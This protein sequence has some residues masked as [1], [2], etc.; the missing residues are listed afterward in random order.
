MSDNSCAGRSG[1][2]GFAQD[3]DNILSVTELDYADFV[4][5][6]GHFEITHLQPHA[7]FHVFKHLRHNAFAQLKA[8]SRLD[9]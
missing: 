1:A 4:R 3:L 5:T 7:V 2:F 8:F 9:R 6:L